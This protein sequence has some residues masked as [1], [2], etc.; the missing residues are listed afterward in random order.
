MP[1]IY[2]FVARGTTVLA[3][4][5]PYSGNYCNIAVAC[6]SNI[7]NPEPKFTIASD[8]HT[9]NFLVYNGYTY[10]VV[11]D[12]AYG[13]QIPFA[14]LERVRDEFDKAH[15][16]AGRI[17]LEGALNGSFSSR[18]KFHMK[19]CMEHPEEIDRVVAMRQKV[20]DVKGIMM[21]NIERVIDRGEKIEVLGGKAEDLSASAHTFQKKGKQLRRAMCWQNWKWKILVLVLLCVLVVVIF[22]A[23]C[24]YGGN[25]CIESKSLPGFVPPPMPMPAAPGTVVAPSPGAVVALPPP[26]AP[27]APGPP[28]VAPTDVP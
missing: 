17:A 15:A 18:L 14:F 23:V 24:F 2:S 25:N 13:R 26:R 16:Q 27:F 12:E 8:Q 21:D 10:L 11:A 5:A 1:L 19:Y 28:P 22:C 20:S 9:F 6:L 7:A 3:E 4:H